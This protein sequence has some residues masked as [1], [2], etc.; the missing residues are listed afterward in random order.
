[1]E[2]FRPG[3]IN[4]MAHLIQG[5]LAS[6]LLFGTAIAFAPTVQA[7]EAEAPADKSP[8]ALLGDSAGGTNGAP[9]NPKTDNPSGTAAAQADDPKIVTSKK[10]NVQSKSSINSDAVQNSGASNTYEAVQNVPGVTQSDA[11]GGAVADNV[12]IRGIHLNSVTGYRLEGGM[13]IVNNLIQPLEDKERIETLKGA[14][15]LA[16][17][18]ASPA[19]VINY[20][21]KRA[22][23]LPI[24]SFGVS[25]NNF[26]QAIGTFDAGARFGQ[27]KQFGLRTVISGGGVNAGVHNTEGT[28]GLG[29]LAFDWTPNDR[30]ALKADFEE[31]GVDTIEQA[32]LLQLAP[33]NGRVP[34][35]KVIPNYYPL[36]SGPWAKY[37]GIGQNI[38]IAGVYRLDY[39]W[40]VLTEAGRSDTR[41]FQRSASQ[42]GNYDINTG[43]GKESVTLT[44]NQ[45]FYNT[46]LRG[47]LR[48]HFEYAFLTN[49][50]TLGI[51]RNERNS[52][53]NLNP[54]VSVP[55]N[56]YTPFNTITPPT[57]Y[58]AAYAPQNDSDIGY[59]AS[60]DVGLFNRIHLLGGVRQVEYEGYA[61]PKNGGTLRS[62]N[63]SFTAPS[64]G[65]VVTIMPGAE[66]Y[67]SYVESLQETGEAPINAANAFDILPPA[68]ADQKEIGVR[69]TNLYNATASLA[70]F[71][72]H[73]ANA[74]IDPASNIYAI[75]GVQ[76]VRGI[77]GTLRYK[78]LPRLID[79]TL[80]AGGQIGYAVQHSPNPLLNNMEAE[81]T[82]RHSGNIGLVYRPDF[83]RGLT[84]NTNAL[85]TGSR[86]LTN[87]QQG[88]IPAVTIFGIGANYATSL[89]GHR[90][91]YNVSCQNLLNK[92]YYSSAVNGALGIGKPRTIFFGGRIDY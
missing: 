56:I 17:G 60:S 67:A 1:M 16:F 58:P 65:A 55:Q 79:L 23:A 24:L 48:N 62:S 13:P 37:Q 76:D 77:E 82:P 8:T 73:Q 14:S 72:L 81:N 2:L 68:Q 34:L 15:A 6:L 42:I 71:R 88:K 10:S 46:Y 49:D 21:L 12:Q 78:I 40:S 38:L 43:L 59:Y 90:L 28:K 39:G 9:R 53:G 64:V 92:S 3:G 47:E 44:N 83:V 11:K 32:S 27:D 86:E 20:T 36:R 30:F 84:V 85:Y 41:K 33:V 18:L 25:A 66:V 69:V 57:P 22:T 80:I 29:A 61:V 75:N 63:F 70:V 50:L 4:D 74:V 52:N 51:N 5:G 89:G 19:G 35:P 26:G 7:G 54:T 91:T 87:S 31:V 45:Y